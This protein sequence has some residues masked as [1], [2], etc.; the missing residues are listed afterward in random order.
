MNIAFLRYLKSMYSEETLYPYYLKNILSQNS[1]NLEILTYN[2]ACSLK[3]KLHYDYYIFDINNY[4]TYK[5]VKNIIE[6]NNISYKK[7]IMFGY[8]VFNNYYRVISHNMDIPYFVIYGDLNFIFNLI[9]CLKNNLYNYPYGIIINKNGI[10]SFSKSN[11]TLH[12]K[13]YLNDNLSAISKRNIASLQLSM[14]C[15]KKCGYCYFSCYWRSNIYFMDINTISKEIIKIKNNYKIDRISFHD[16]SFDNNNI[17]RIYSF[18][19]KLENQNIKCYFKATFQTQNL[20]NTNKKV[21]KKL[22]DVG[23]YSIFTSIDAANDYDLKLYNKN[24]SYYDINETMSFLKE[25][26]INYVIG[27]INFNP[28]TNKN[29]LIKNL[30]FLQKYK[31]AADFYLLSNKLRIEKKSYLYSRLKQDHL[32]TVINNKLDYKFLNSNINNIYLWT[33]EYCE[34]SKSYLDFINYYIV[35]YISSVY[36]LMCKHNNLSDIFNDFF[37]EYEKIIEILNEFHCAVYSDILFR[38]NHLKKIDEVFYHNI[39]KKFNNLSFK[40]KKRLYRNN[41]DLKDLMQ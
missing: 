32:L 21:F 34:K 38:Y 19:K 12:Y 1:V 3:N 8:Y 14:G 41:I 4:E 36:Y 7:I 11:S 15:D 6:K 28:Y 33:L 37:L 23:L 13:Y 30:L 10:I 18:I 39:I 17:D 16:L 2:E 22:K 5:T 9:I 25:Q 29:S 24:Y 27:F 20:N 40:L 35:E 31:L 26:S